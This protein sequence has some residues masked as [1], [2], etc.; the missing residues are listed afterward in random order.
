MFGVPRTRGSKLRQPWGQQT[1]RVHG[2]R[3]CV[4]LTV[5]LLAAASIL[6]PAWAEPQS[7]RAV[8]RLPQRET[9]DALRILVVAPERSAERVEEIYDGLRAAGLLVV[10]LDERAGV[11]QAGPEPL[12]EGSLDEAR[13]ALATARVAFRELDLDRARDDV[14]RARDELLRLER[15]DMARELLIDVL[16]LD[17]WIA[18]QRDDSDDVRMALALVAR[19]EPTRASLHAGLYP[20]SLVE[21]YAAARAWA[22]SQAP[23]SLIVEPR[24]AGFAVPEIFVDG[25]PLAGSEPPRAGPHIVT[26]RALGAAAFTRLVSTTSGQTLVLE[27]FLA[28]RDAASLRTALLGAAATAST[29]GDAAALGAALEQMAQ[30]CAAR[31]VVFLGAERTLLWAPTRALEELKVTPDAP[32]GVLG[33]FTLA[34]LQAPARVAVGLA[35]KRDDGD[36]M[37]TLL[38][39]VG[40]TGGLALVAAAIGTALWALAPPSP[41]APPPRPVVVR[42]CVD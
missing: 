36:A 13:A 35:P 24:V 37:T 17:A 20:P 7:P 11:D 28:P 32:G 10:G 6:N 22:E 38:L 25:R 39:M 5:A 19:L 31:A 23:V 15:P 21:A 9:L 18:L 41:P 1:S 34:A 33:Q 29:T 12:A 4:H 27:P 26:V 14:R 8:Q 40:G 2:A 3:P 42:C 30:L 16:I